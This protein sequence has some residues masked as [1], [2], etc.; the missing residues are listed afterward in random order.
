MKGEFGMNYKKQLYLNTSKKA[1]ISFN[2]HRPRQVFLDTLSPKSQQNKV[3]TWLKDS[4][5]LP[6]KARG[7]HKKI[8]AAGNG[9][10]TLRN[11]GFFGKTIFVFDDAIKKIIHIFKGLNEKM[12][13]MK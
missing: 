11:Y 13:G 12:R 10:K 5:A 7:K 4:M 2:L 3:F 8:I 9:L 6:Q 1:D